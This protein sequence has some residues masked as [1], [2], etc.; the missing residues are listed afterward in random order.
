MG[1]LKEIG[2]FIVSADPFVQHDN[3]LTGN[4]TVNNPLSLNETLLW[5]GEPTASTNQITISENFSNFDRVRIY[6][7][8]YERRYVDEVW[9]GTN[10]GFP[11]VVGAIF[12]NGDGNYEKSMTRWN[13]SNGTTYNWA[14]TIHGSFTG[15]QTNTWNKDVIPMRI[16]G[17]NRKV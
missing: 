8:S 15:T 9:A 3:S 11:I 6:W 2:G 14:A 12:V 13:C 4:G 17:V 10:T 5:S 7:K 16:V 1:D